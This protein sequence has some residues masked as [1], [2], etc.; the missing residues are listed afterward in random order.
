MRAR[1][2]SR[3]AAICALL[4]L[5]VTAALAAPAAG[6]LGDPRSDLARA[7]AGTAQYRDVGRAVTA[8]YAEFRDAAGIACI[9]KPGVGGMGIHYV[10]PGV[11]DI[12]LDPATPEAL[13]YEPG[14]HG[15]LR[16]VAAEYIVFQK[17]WDEANH[18]PPS[19]FGQPFTLVPGGP[20]PHGNRYGIPAFYELHAWL[21]KWNPR[22]LFDDWNPRVSCRFA[23]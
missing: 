4:A 9:D 20:L 15:A 7:Y 22:G 3:R 13:V 1:P 8:R 12:D 23:P 21:W 18:A 19:L 10:G 5:A 2:G 6:R 17:Q 11:G 16:L 14:P